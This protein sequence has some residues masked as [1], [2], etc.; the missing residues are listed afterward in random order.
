MARAKKTKY[1]K[2]FAPDGEHFI[3]AG[4]VS[5]W[6]K[7]WTW[8]TSGNVRLHKLLFPKANV[9]IVNLQTGQRVGD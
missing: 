4:I 9:R 6:E 7:A 5:G 8:L 3:R 2:E 1:A